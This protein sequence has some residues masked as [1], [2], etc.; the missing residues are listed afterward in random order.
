M[1]AKTIRI[2]TYKLTGALTSTKPTVNGPR[3]PSS[4]SITMPR[5]NAPTI[6]IVI[7]QPAAPAIVATDMF[8][9]RVDAGGSV[10]RIKV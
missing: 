5:T 1:S 2:T 8:E 7:I 4:L 9:M 6:A 3:N 10:I